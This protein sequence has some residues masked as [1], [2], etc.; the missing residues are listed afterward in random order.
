MASLQLQFGQSQSL[1]CCWKTENVVEVKRRKNE[2]VTPP[3]T[4]VKFTRVCDEFETEERAKNGYGRSVV[5]QV[6]FSRL[7]D[8]LETE[9]T[10]Q[11]FKRADL[12]DTVF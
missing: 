12:T 11:N 8:K 4:Q 7:C 6:I 5:R 10:V 3:T 1:K 9:K 2:F